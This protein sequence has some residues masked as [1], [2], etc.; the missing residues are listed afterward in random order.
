LKAS[1]EAGGPAFSSLF[2]P[3]P[4]AQKPLYLH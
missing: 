3:G 2:G 4:I 1:A